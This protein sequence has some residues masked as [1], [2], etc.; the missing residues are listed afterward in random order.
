MDPLPST[1]R[2]EWNNGTRCVTTQQI[3]GVNIFSGKGG[4][5]V[6][7]WVR[8]MKYILE[9]KGPAAPLVQFNEI[10]RHTGGRARDL[11]LNL[12]LSGD[13]QL[14][15]AAAFRELLEEYGES[16]Y[17]SSAMAN[18]YSRV[19]QTSESASEYAV[20]LE[21]KLRAAKDR[22]EQA[23]MVE[24]PTRDVMLTTQFM[25]GLRDQAVK[26]RLA[27]MRPREMSFRELRRELRVIE[28]E[29]KVTSAQMYRQEVTKQASRESQAIEDLTRAMQQL[30]TTQQQQ[31]ELFHKTVEDQERRLAAFQNQME[32]PWAPQ[33]VTWTRGMS[34]GGRQPRPSR[35]CYTCGQPGHFSTSCPNRP[36]VHGLPQQPLN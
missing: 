26:A 36:P 17:L 31:M 32:K 16:D 12:E 14:T 24:Q 5:K 27:P 33:N 11:I 1:T 21:A 7:D 8:D 29:E 23:A 18:F 28:A 20:A 34:R 10:V 13:Q 35:A 9:S 3:K 19:Q 6:E 22:G 25:Q 4:P 2:Q 30:A 15:P